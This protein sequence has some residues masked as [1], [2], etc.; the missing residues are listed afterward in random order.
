MTTLAPEVLEKLRTYDTPTICNIVELFEVRPYTSG[1]MDR[2]IVAAYPDLPSMVGFA[3][4]ATLRTAAPPRNGDA[5]A[6]IQEQIER[7]GELSGPPVV[8]LQDLDDPS[9]AAS[10]GE[11]MCTTYQTF[12]AL[13]LITS[14]SGRDLAQVRALNFPVFSNGVCCAHGYHHLL[15][16]H[17]PVHVGGLTVYPDDLL[18]G[19]GNGVTTIP[20]EIAAEVAD[21]G[22][23][24]VAAEAVILDALRL[25]SPSPATY[26]VAR[27]EANARIA[28]LREQ[29]SRA[30]R[31]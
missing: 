4:T 29:V 1:Y 21:V 27:A 9:A 16:V 10:Y 6:G 3:A 15:A 12:G 17:V 7:F 11:V 24:Y 19:D 8:V 20:A 25:G 18:H 31:V 22:Y 13:G 26:A 28:K 23:E 14:G 30:L 5:Y 2:R